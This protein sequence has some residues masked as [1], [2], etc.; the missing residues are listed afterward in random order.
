MSLFTCNCA[1]CL[2]AVER[3][4][5]MP[6]QELMEE[7]AAMTR[8]MHIRGLVCV[9]AYQEFMSEEQFKRYVSVVA[10]AQERAIAGASLQ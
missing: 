2:A 7:A 3:F 5:R 1:K 9:S 8:A 6:Q 10:A 4:I